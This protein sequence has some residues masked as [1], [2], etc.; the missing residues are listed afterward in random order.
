[1]LPL[2]AVVTQHRACVSPAECIGSVLTLYQLWFCLGHWY[3]G[4]GN[5]GCPL[6][7]DFTGISERSTLLIWFDLDI[8]S[9][10]FLWD[11][12]LFCCKS[13][14][15][16]G[17]RQK[18]SFSTYTRV[19]HA[20]R[21]RAVGARRFLLLYLECLQVGSGKVRESHREW[22]LPHRQEMVWGWEG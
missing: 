13:M 22:Q 17:T 11:L 21:D 15:R 7:A 19:A 12:F 10:S 2:A 4:C 18:R 16:G 20:N 14:V 9:Q 1:M 8:W 3:P 5:W 6:S